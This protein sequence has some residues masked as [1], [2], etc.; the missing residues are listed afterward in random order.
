MPIE[1]TD[2]EL[3]NI[4]ENI[5]LDESNN[6]NEGN[7]STQKIIIQ[8]VNAKI[9]AS[10]AVATKNFGACTTT[11]VANNPG[12]FREKMIASTIQAQTLLMKSHIDLLKEL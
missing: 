1:I 12:S 10:N 3:L 4:V 8:D 6:H 7:S 9:G 2:P 11:S 5:F